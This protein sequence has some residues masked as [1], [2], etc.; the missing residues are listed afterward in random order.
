MSQDRGPLG[1]FAVLV[2]SSSAEARDRVRIAL[3]PRPSTELAPVRF[4]DAAT[5]PDVVRLCDQGGIDLAILD[6]EAWP[7]G[8]IGLA[9]QLRDELAFSPPTLLLLGRRD[10]AWLATWSRADAV[11]AYPI[12]PV[13]LTE[14]VVG[15]LSAAPSRR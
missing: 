13:R 3:G 15:L 4:V 10:D 14:A 6:G 9:R 12:D 5:G 2:Y 11:V 7:T 1:E 8:G